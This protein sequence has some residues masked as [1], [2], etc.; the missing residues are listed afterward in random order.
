MLI[1]RRTGQIVS[2][3]GYLF[4]I[5]SFI[6]I[7]TFFG[8]GYYILDNYGKFFTLLYVVLTISFL[9]YLASKNN[10]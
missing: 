6:S 1:N 4:Q 7:L 9:I 3:G 5:K 10:D 8:I 2:K